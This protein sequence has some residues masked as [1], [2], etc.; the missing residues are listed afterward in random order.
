MPSVYS[1]FKCPFHKSCFYLLFVFLV[2]QSISFPLPTCKFHISVCPWIH[3]LE[4]FFTQKTHLAPLCKQLS[5][6]ILMN[7]SQEVY[8][9]SQQA[10]FLTIN[11]DH[12]TI[13]QPEICL[14]WMDCWPSRAKHY[15]YNQ[16][17]SLVLGSSSVLLLKLN[18]VPNNSTVSLILTSI[19]F[20]SKEEEEE[21]PIPVSLGKW[22]VRDCKGYKCCK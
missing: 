21:D 7:N 22:S 12:S 6:Q 14:S 11:R 3:Q 9:T 4:E 17:C 16:V 5:D 1:D 19:L 13:S 10:V 8:R 18:L 20:K 2:P 15:F